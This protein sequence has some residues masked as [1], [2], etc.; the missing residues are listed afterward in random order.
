MIYIKRPLSDLIIESTIESAEN[1]HSFS[2]SEIVRGSF[3]VIVSSSPDL[4]YDTIVCGCPTA[5]GFGQKREL[6][7]LIGDVIGKYLKKSALESDFCA[8][9]AGLGNPYVTPDSLGTLAANKISVDGERIFSVTPLTKAKTGLDTASIVRF[10]AKESRADVIIA[11]DSLSAR[12][13]ERLASVIQITDAGITPGSGVSGASSEISRA[14]MSCP[15]ISVG[16]PTVIRPDMLGSYDGSLLVTPA[17]VDSVTET[18]SSLIASGIN[19]SL[20]GNM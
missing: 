19:L 15:V 4:S 20:R 2:H 5:L 17:S 7:C 12:F 13:K 3:S 11:V 6:Y 18:F 8:L 1:N 10:A 14:T 16:V 9:V